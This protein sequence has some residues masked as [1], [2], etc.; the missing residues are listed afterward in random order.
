VRSGV[1]TD[2][3]VGRQVSF[4]FAPGPAAKLVVRALPVR[5]DGQ[6]LDVLLDGERVVSR[7]VD[8][9]L[10]DLRL[11]VPASERSRR[12]DL[13][14]AKVAPISNDDP[15][16]AAARLDR[17]D[18]VPL[19]APIALRVPN[20]LG[21]PG[22]EHDGI[23]ADGWVGAEAYVVLGGGPEAALA[24]QAEVAQCTRQHLTVT[25]NGD[26]VYAAPVAPGPLY[27][28]LPV[29]AAEGERRVEL[30]W[31]ATAPLPGPDGREVSALLG[32]IGVASGEPPMAIRTF[33]RDLLTGG[34]SG[35]GIYRD[36]WLERE[37]SIVLRGGDATSL[38][39][40]ADVLDI[41]NQRLA[42][43][44]SGVRVWEGDVA[45][46]PLG[47][48]ES[49]E[50]SSAPRRVELAWS[51]GARLSSGDARIVAAQLRS[52][53][54]GKVDTPSAISLSEELNDYGVSY[55]GLYRDG[56]MLERAWIGLAGGDAGDLVVRG[57]VPGGQSRE[58][59]LAVDGV[60]VFERWLASG[61]A[62]IR[63]R[64][65]TSTVNRRI[66]FEWSSA[67]QLTEADPRAV[68]ARLGFIGITR[69]GGVP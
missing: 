8:C 31:A 40:F 44:I 48:V 47:I 16:L 29:A 43:S 45:A 23:A 55:G 11:P 41:P 57:F 1:H 13:Q 28:R 18:L 7:A 30:R 35:H 3:W 64:I 68:A 22:V 24:I 42:V 10:V 17:L 50:A 38:S 61:E 49:I 2:G 34:V 19:R 5:C 62:E 60:P 59:S 53:E 15:R 39:L 26:E 12:V 67:E 56:W 37:S 9:E 33:P 32:F 54:L 69:P 21:I 46:G 20:H 63:V 14:W 25:V 65:A 4:D 66:E 27:L 36:G 58:L 51:N 52:I 6:R